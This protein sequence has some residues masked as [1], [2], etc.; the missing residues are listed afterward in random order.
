M[1][2]L[3][4]PLPRRQ[5]L[6]RI[7]PMPSRWVRSPRAR[8]TPMTR[9]RKTH[10]LIGDAA[11][12]IDLLFSSGVMMAMSSAAFGATVVEGLLEG[13]QPQERL[14]RDY[15]RRYGSALVRCHG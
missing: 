11:A 1:L 3:Q 4:A 8:I 9:G 14:V 12:F 13:Q 2:F 7:W 6:P 5:A 15:E 10:I